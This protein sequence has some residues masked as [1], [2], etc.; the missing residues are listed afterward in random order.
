VAVAPACLP[1]GRVSG[2]TDSAEAVSSDYLDGLRRAGL[3]PAVTG[4]A[5]S[6]GSDGDDI[7]GPWAGLVLCGGPDVDPQRYR[8]ET[9]PAVYGVD[10]RRDAHEVGLV[11]AALDAGRPVL[12]ICRGLQVL[13]VA[14]GGTL[15]QHLPDLPRLIAH[16]VPVGA[17]E[18]AVHPVEV[19]AGS[20]LAAAVDSTRI[21]AC[22]SIHHQAVDSVADGLVVTARSRDGV[23][24]A[25]EPTD[26]GTWCLAVQWHPERSA[27][28]DGAQQAIFGAFA[29]AVRRSVG[30]T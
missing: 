14:L 8:E 10:D 18:P 11:R 17:G 20:R 27:A 29:D 22:V 25:L 16:G 24:E 28:R 1:A 6:A 26:P 2:W 12:A 5:P 7:L 21:D 13:N 9:H 30:S 19:T 4:P 23:V 3:R 15:V